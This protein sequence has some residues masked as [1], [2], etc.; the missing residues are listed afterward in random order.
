MLCYNH[1]EVTKK[2][3]QLN[4]NIECFC[5]SIGSIYY[6]CLAH[7]QPGFA[8]SKVLAIGKQIASVP[9]NITSAKGNKKKLNNF[10]VEASARL[11]ICHSKQL[12]HRAIF[13]K[14]IGFLFANKYSKDFIFFVFLL[15]ITCFIKHNYM[16]FGHIYN[17]LSFQNTM[18]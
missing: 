17:M 2:F 7:F 12:I 14:S 6:I 5:H 13:V 4:K 10:K 8:E 18:H 11:P 15:L 16:H 3:I 9:I 1:C